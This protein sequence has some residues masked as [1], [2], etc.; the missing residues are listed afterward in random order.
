VRA[1]IGF[2]GSAMGVPIRPVLRAE[3]APVVRGPQNQVVG[4]THW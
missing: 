3:I 1:S 4:T 2:D